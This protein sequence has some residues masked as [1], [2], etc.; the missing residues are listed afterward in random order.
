MSRLLRPGLMGSLLVAL[1]MAPPAVAQE[2][3]T[4]GAPVR[5]GG[6]KTDP[7]TDEFRLVMGRSRGRGETPTRF[8]LL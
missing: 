1:L 6:T 2:K 8:K 4:P 7:F 5:V 3:L